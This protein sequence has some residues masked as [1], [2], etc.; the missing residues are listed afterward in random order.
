MW[1]GS[2]SSSSIGPKRLPPEGRAQEWS[3]FAA[4][5]AERELICRNDRSQ[6]FMWFRFFGFHYSFLNTRSAC[7]LTESAWKLNEMRREKAQRLSSERERE[8]K[9]DSHH[10]VA[11]Y[12]ANLTK[13]FCSQD[14]PFPPFAICYFFF[15]VLGAAFAAVPFIPYMLLVIYVIFCLN[16][17]L[18]C[19]RFD[20]EHQNG[21]VLN[22]F[23]SAQIIILPAEFEP[24]PYHY[25][26]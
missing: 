18:L 2:A 20:F 1:P 3:Y 11:A 8:N 19:A 9:T 10:K 22:D 16:K 15:L 24:I 12:Y 23:V 21:A 7:R 5:H 13:D 17:R 26:K 14:F 25:K 6:L 4:T